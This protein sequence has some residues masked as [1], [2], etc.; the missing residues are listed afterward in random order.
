MLNI[1]EKY[2]LPEQLKYLFLRTS[3]L[4][5]FKYI[6]MPYYYRLHVNIVYYYQNND[7]ECNI[8]T[9]TLYLPF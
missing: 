7:N 5:N 1:Q 9:D 4:K 2:Y 8:Y 3:E 6:R